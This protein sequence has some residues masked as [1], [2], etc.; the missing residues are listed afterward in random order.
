VQHHVQPVLDRE[1]IDEQHHQRNVPVTRIHEKHVNE[2]EGDRNAYLALGQNHKDTVQH[3][4]GERQVVDAGETVNETVHH[5]VHNVIQPIIE[6]ET[7]APTRIHTTVP[8]HHTVHE[9]P[10]VHSSIAHEPMARDAF[11]QQGGKL[12][13]KLTH[14]STADRLLGGDC[15]RTVDG[16]GETMLQKMGIGHSGVTGVHTGTGAATTGPN[17]AARV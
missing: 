7:I 3:V 14:E 5:H 17:G 8:L 6:K 16:E 4:Q 1:E 13:E 2:D 15:E 11:L 10:I 9:A 12:G